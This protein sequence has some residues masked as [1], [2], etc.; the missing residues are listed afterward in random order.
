MVNASITPF[1]VGEANT[2]NIVSDLSA[3]AA[4]HPFERERRVH[5]LSVENRYWCCMF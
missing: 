5:K 2:E 4:R 1:I 3:G